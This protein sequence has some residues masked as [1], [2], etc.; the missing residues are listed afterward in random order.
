MFNIRVTIPIY[1]LLHT[2]H[3]KDLAGNFFNKLW[4]STLLCSY[5]NY[6]LCQKYPPLISFKFMFF[7]DQFKE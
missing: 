2:S 7:M 5:L 4:F 1:F 6:A 3:S